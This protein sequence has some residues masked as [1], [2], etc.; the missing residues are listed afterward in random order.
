MKPLPLPYHILHRAVEFYHSV[1]AARRNGN[2]AR[3]AYP[4]PTASLK[5]R[6]P[7]REIRKSRTHCLQNA[8]IVPKEHVIGHRNS[9]IFQHV[10]MRFQI[11]STINTQS[12]CQAKQRKYNGIQAKPVNA[13]QHLVAKVSRQIRIRF[14]EAHVAH[15]LHL[16]HVRI[17]CLGILIIQVM[18]VVHSPSLSVVILHYH[19]IFP[20]KIQ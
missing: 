7:R 3:H 10:L 17:T 4:R 11:F 2:T 19:I 9:T 14:I 15:V 13:T 18:S 1:Q 6:L 20:P 8:K 16:D 5:I 12:V